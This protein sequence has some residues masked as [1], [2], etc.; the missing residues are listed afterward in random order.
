MEITEWAMIHDSYGTYAADTD[1]LHVHLREAFVALYDN[2]NPLMEFKVAQEQR[3]GI[4]LPE[5]PK[6]G[7]FDVRLVL[8]SPYFFG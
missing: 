3:T 6:Q 7:D 8:D 4:E 5:P 2:V 1:A